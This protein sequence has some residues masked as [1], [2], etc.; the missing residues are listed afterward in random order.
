MFINL[1]S[2]HGSDSTQNADPK[3]WSIDE[4]GIR[5]CCCTRL[6]EGRCDDVG[7]RGHVGWVGI[8]GDGSADL[9]GERN[10]ICRQGDTSVRG[11]DVKRS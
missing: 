11:L 6:A 8:L 3:I 2:Q 7:G 4:S 9:C 1:E 10:D 5:R